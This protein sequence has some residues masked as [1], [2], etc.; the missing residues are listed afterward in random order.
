MGAKGFDFVSPQA[1]MRE[2]AEL[3]PIYGGISYERINGA[4]LQWPCLD[5][6][7]PGTQY[8][9]ENQFSRGK[10]NFVSLQYKPPLE[11]ADDE[12]PLI[13]TTGRSRYHFHTGVMT[14]KV[15]GLNTLHPEELVQINPT[16]AD[17]QGIADGDRISVSSRRGKIEAKARVTE[18]VP[19]GLVFM[20]F[21]F[22]ESS[23][24]VLTNPAYDPVSKI[25]EL[26]VSAVKVQKV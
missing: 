15:D 8:L 12:Y 26:K 3:T 20:T 4:G 6:D 11:Q 5:A 16:D 25:P 24:N 21:H 7:H 14:R 2:I 1:I 10:G 17:A 23:A 9:H 22:A 13:M 18:E 19:A